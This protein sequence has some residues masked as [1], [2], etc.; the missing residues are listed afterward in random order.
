VGVP[1]PGPALQGPLLRHA[2]AL[3]VTGDSAAF[4]LL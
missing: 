1:D 2:L 3:A 4:L